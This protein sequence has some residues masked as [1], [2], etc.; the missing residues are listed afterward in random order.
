MTLTQHSFEQFAYLRDRLRATMSGVAEVFDELLEPGRAM[1]VR[2]AD[3]RLM[4]DRFKVVLLGEMKAGKSTLIN[5]L[6]GERLV[7]SDFGVACTAIPISVR[8]GERSRALCFRPTGEAPEEIDLVRDRAQFWEAVSISAGSRGR[9]DLDEATARDLHPFTHAIVESPIPLLSHGVELEDTPGT[10]E[11]RS[12]TRAA[13]A[14]VDQSGAVIVLLSCQQIG[15]QSDEDTLGE[16]GLRGLDP[17]VV[18]VVWNYLDMCRGDDEAARRVKA[19]ALA[20]TQRLGVPADHVCLVSAKEGLAA[21][22][23]GDA[24]ALA[25]SGIPGLESALASFLMD[26]RAAAKLLTPLGTVTRA[27]IEAAQVVLPS[28]KTQWS[29]PSRVSAEAVRDGKILQRGLERVTAELDTVLARRGERAV[30]EA[31]SAVADLVTELVEGVGNVVRAVPLSSSDAL[32][33]KA[34]ARRLLDERVQEWVSERVERWEARE[35]GPLGREY[36]DEIRRDVSLA[37]T[38]LLR[39]A[40]RA[41]ENRDRAA[42]AREGAMVARPASQ[43]NAAGLAVEDAGVDRRALDVDELLEGMTFDTGFSEAAAFGAAAAVGV[44]I[45]AA[46]LLPF[47]LIAAGLWTLIRGA[48]AADVLKERA[49]ET[50]VNGIRARSGD[51]ESLVTEKVRE[52]ARN[53]VAS[54]KGEI[55]SIRK[56]IEDHVDQTAKEHATNVRLA[57]E[58]LG[59]LTRLQA[60]LRGLAEEIDALGREIDPTRDAE[61]LAERIARKVS[62]QGGAT[63]D[64]PERGDGDSAPFRRTLSKEEIEL[65]LQ[66]DPRIRERVDQVAA[67]LTEHDSWTS[68]SRMDLLQAWLSMPSVSVQAKVQVPTYRTVTA[69]AVHAGTEAFPEPEVVR[70]WWR[71]ET[72]RAILLELHEAIDGER[73]DYQKASSERMREEAVEQFVRGWRRIRKRLM[74]GG[75]ET[76][77]PGA[78]SD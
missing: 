44:A 3:R 26:E 11:N 72:S 42:R 32:M 30:R 49:I 53:T 23:D 59:L 46:P 2:D 17:R 19:A 70:E 64:S 78:D 43:V 25:S 58:R 45:L 75:A 4:E 1:A 57:D 48:S 34:A 22:V 39:I 54:I 10:N 69:M 16:V 71:V 28:R 36:S 63:D 9:R 8:W 6:L 12:R 40:D 47:A 24:A 13:W 38:E 67:V 56:S 41:E 62:P 21:K 31:R 29:R 73:H 60:R 52:V 51:L 77:D 7:P 55:D 5:A 18:F 68:V 14:E 37:L 76:A 65:K 61:R 33:D 50:I 27:V 15:R 66:Q 35:I 20:M 74:A